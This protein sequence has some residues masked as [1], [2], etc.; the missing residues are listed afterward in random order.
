MNFEWFI[1]RTELKIHCR[2][3]S[4]KDRNLNEKIQLKFIVNI[5]QNILN[6]EIEEGDVPTFLETAHKIFS[7][8]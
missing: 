1:D 3:K 5:Y 4:V 2:S 6:L 7:Q 8:I